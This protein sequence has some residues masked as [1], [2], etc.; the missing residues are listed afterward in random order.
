MPFTRRN[1]N[2][3]RRFR[4]RRPYTR[5][6][7]F[8]K[9][10]SMSRFRSSQNQTYKTFWFNES[11]DVTAGVG[12][13]E[14]NRRFNVSSLLAIQQ[15]ISACYLYEQYRVIKIVLTLYPSGNNSEGVFNR[16][17]RGNIVS[18]MDPPPYNNVAPVN[19]QQVINNSSCRMH[20]TRSRIKRY[21]YRP[22]EQYNSWALIGRTYNTT[23]PTPQPITDAWGTRICI[24]GTDFNEPV[25]SNPPVP[26]PERIDNTYYFY[27]L[28]F[29]VQMKCRVDT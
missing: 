26:V 16:Y 17:H 21:L 23:P 29:L 15:F 24:F 7:R 3:K 20:Y 13:G 8:N 18:F 10:G 27:K 19:I 25:P 28:S 12:N 1:Y 4:R 6:N 22:K 9:I 11:G 2:A 14:I 5:L